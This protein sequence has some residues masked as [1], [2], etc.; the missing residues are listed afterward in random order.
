MSYPTSEIPVKKKDV[1]Q[2]I[3][4]EEGSCQWVV[5]EMRHLNP[6][7]FCP[8]GHLR[9]KS[10]GDYYS[11]IEAILGEKE[12][13]NIPDEEIDRLYKE[14]AER[15]LAQLTI[16]EELGVDESDYLFDVDENFRGDY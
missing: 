13:G 11:C 3:I 14:E 8:L 6:C 4:A 1:L 15:V 12:H 10:N 5:Y 9:R 7:R 16:N 2:K